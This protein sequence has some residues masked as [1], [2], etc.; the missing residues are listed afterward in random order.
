MSIAK[1]GVRR[2][3]FKPFVKTV[4]GGGYAKAGEAHDVS[5]QPFSGG[6]AAQMYGEKASAMLL[7]YAPLTVPFGEG[8]GVCV[9]VAGDKEPDYKVVYAPRWAGHM[10]M[11][12]ER[13]PKRRNEHSEDQAQ[14]FESEAN[15]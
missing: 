13:L 14:K 1:K 10:V 9:D 7:V 4:R 2:L 11:H 3:T 12:L 15:E 8:A 5:V 6:T